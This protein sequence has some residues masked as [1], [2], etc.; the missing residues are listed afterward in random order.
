[1]ISIFDNI[2]NSPTIEAFTLT[3]FLLCVL[4]GLL[5]GAMVAM[6]Y[7]SRNEHTESFI[8][9]IVMMPAIVAIIIIAVNGS[10]GTGIAVAGAFALVRFRSAPGKAKEIGAI[11]LAMGAGLLIGI[12]Y[13]TYSLLFTL[14]LGVF[15]A[16][17]E[18]LS[19]EKA[20][21]SNRKV[22]NITVPEDLDYTG[23]MDG[24]LSKYTT[25]SH[26]KKVKSTNMG[27]MFRLTYE[28]DLVSDCNVKSMLD[29][30]RCRNGNL[31]VS[32]VDADT[33]SEASAL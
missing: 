12:G 25:Y 18:K 20:D 3:Q 21:P 8:T 19:D 6:F 32:L 22:L 17:Y 30:I 28:V 23:V 27:S 1:M 7:A 15:F 11:F 14:I 16:L 9:T 31:E 2:F 26:M 13:L 33:G 29:E 10:I 4:C 5:A 24:I